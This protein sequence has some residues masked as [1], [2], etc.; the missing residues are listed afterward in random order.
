MDDHSKTADEM[1]KELPDPP[2]YEI[3]YDRDSVAVKN[4]RASGYYGVMFA[5][6]Y[7]WSNRQCTQ[8]AY[9]EFC[10]DA[11]PGKRHR[12]IKGQPRR[13][14]KFHS[15]WMKVP[16]AKPCLRE[17]GSYNRF[18]GYET[19]DALDDLPTPCRVVVGRESSPV[20]YVWTLDAPAAYDVFENLI[21]D[22]D[23]IRDDPDAIVPATDYRPNELGG[24]PEADTFPLRTVGKG[25]DD[26]EAGVPT[27]LRAWW[28]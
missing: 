10:E 14:L 2:E 27:I 7:A 19:A 21:V 23:P 24:V 16:E 28:D 12:T 22:D 17:I 9:G 25:R 13:S 3:P 6:D 8:E 4:A 11:Q 5:D 1:A 15:T 18:D 26:L 20:M